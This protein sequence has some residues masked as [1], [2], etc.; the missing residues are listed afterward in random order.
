MIFLCPAKMA[1]WWLITL[2]FI[3]VSCNNCFYLRAF[4]IKV[5]FVCNQHS[6]VTW[7]PTSL[8]MLATRPSKAETRILHSSTPLYISGNSIQSS[9]ICDILF[10]M[11]TLR[12]RAVFHPGPETDSSKFVQINIRS[13]A[14]KS[15]P[16]FQIWNL[17]ARDLTLPAS[18]V[19]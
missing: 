18:L 5:D 1:S 3:S 16:N 7:L 9:Q 19:T 2:S 4:A 8:S 11:L 17:E 13:L 15:S 12:L 10:Q 6:T 14:T